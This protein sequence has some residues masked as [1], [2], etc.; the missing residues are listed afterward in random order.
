[1]DRKQV[2]L[3]QINT[4]PAGNSRGDYGDIEQLARR[5]QSFGL[6]GVVRL[7][8]SGGSTYAIEDG[9]RRVAAI[10]S[11]LDAGVTNSDS[12]E[13]LEVIWA[14]VLDAE[15]DAESRLLTQLALNTSQES[16][17]PY[18]Q[19][20]HIKKMVDEGLEIE[21]IQEKMGL[22]AQA[23]KQRLDL[24][25]ASEPVKEALQEGN[26]SFS[27]ARAIISVP[28]ETLQKSLVE[29]TIADN[30]PS[31]EVE[32]RAVKLTEKAVSQGATTARK[33]KPSAQR[34]TRAKIILRPVTEILSRIEDRQKD[35]EVIK[36][37]I[38]KGRAEG[39]IQALQYVLV[40]KNI[41][42]EEKKRA[43]KSKGKSATSKSA[44][45]KKT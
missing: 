12:G 35:L 3:H 26:I 24:L 21:T 18:D 19:A 23:I 17:T 7:R 10:Q 29:E 32:S 22:G 43:A 2:L 40:D 13:S 30:L 8:P 16:W 9:H 1:M 33:R 42:A 11:L 27:A 37:D 44:K 28:D 45:N 34:S 20:T 38:E 6:Q 31:R 39:Y 14:E 41:I 4:D 25:S 5:I 36:D 15:E